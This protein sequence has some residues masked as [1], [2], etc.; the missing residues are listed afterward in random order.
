MPL[1]DNTDIFA[2]DCHDK[3]S[4]YSLSNLHK[5]YFGIVIWIFTE[6]NNKKRNLLFN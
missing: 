3:Q 5:H 6:T 1:R 4:I 2:K